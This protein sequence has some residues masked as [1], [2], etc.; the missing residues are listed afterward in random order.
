MLRNENPHLSGVVTEDSGGRTRFGIAERFH[1][2]LGDEFYCGPAETSLETA[3]EIYRSEYWQPIRGDEIHD[4]RIATKLLDMAVNMGV[5]QA[6]VLCQRAVNAMSG[7][8]LIED[9]VVGSITLAALN[10]CDAAVLDLHLR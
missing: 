10:G 9:G 7:I 1:P 5:R 8:H 6:I 2:D 4:Q 3:R